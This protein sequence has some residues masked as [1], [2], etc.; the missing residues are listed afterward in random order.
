[1][2]PKPTLLLLSTFACNKYQCEGNMQIIIF[3]I[4]IKIQFER[5]M[6]SI[7]TVQCYFIKI[8][9]VFLV[10][11]SNSYIPGKGILKLHNITFIFFLTSHKKY[12]MINAKHNV[13]NVFCWKRIGQFQTIIFVWLTET[14]E[15]LSILYL[16][17]SSKEVLL[18][19]D[20]ES[21][22]PP[23]KSFLILW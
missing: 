14:E 13:Q 16:V 11:K 21:F 10:K 5:K 17:P 3:K 20:H 22:T 4:N 8:H 1:M 18:A 6:Q 23:S 7:N 15:S 12:I 2:Y 9:L 19:E